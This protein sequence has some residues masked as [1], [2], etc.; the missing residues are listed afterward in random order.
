MVDS[1]IF[2][3]ENDMWG[4]HFNGNKPEPIIEQQLIHQREMDDGQT[5]HFA[6]SSHVKPMHF[7]YMSTLVFPGSYRLELLAAD[8]WGL[9]EL[10]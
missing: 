3:G 9:S 2:S 8:D 6:L 5:K 7:G 10:N 4:Q 1:V